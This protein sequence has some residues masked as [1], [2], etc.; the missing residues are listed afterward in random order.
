M[1]AEKEQT[2]NRIEHDLGIDITILFKALTGFVFFKR[3]DGSIYFDYCVLDI[4]E[5]G[6]YLHH[7]LDN[8][9]KYYT[10][11][12][13]KTWAT[14]EEDFLM[15]KQYKEITCFDISCENCPIK[16]ICIDNLYQTPDEMKN[17]TLQ[18]KLNDS[19]PSLDDEEKEFY[20]KRID[21]IVQGENLK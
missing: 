13:R 21:A 11:D 15:P 18:E 14:K 1:N 16:N 12:Y 3:S 2:I 10:K 5:N 20:Q 17:D 7:R 19:I 6:Y 9:N 8:D 4:D